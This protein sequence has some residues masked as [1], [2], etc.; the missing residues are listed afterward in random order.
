[1]MNWQRDLFAIARQAGRDL[2]RM[3]DALE[4]ITADLLDDRCP[5]GHDRADHGS[6][7]EGPC[8]VTAVNRPDD[9]V[10]SCMRFGSTGVLS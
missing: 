5:C 3:A 4:A 7:G 1:M 9:F 6:A 8:L 2:T 10:C